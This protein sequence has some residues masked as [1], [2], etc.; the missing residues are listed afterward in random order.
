MKNN[1]LHILVA[2]GAG[3][4]GS[5]TTASLINAGHLVTVLDNLSSGYIDAVHPEARFVNGDTSDREV[6][7][8]ICDDGIDVAMHFAA[9]IEVGESV[10]DP[11]K[12]YGNNLVKSIAFFDNLITCGVK[13]L[14]FS[15]TAAVYGEPD[16]IP[17]T[18]DAVLAPVNPYGWSKLMVETVLR[19]YEKAYNFRS[20]SLRY[21]NAGGAFES[22]GERHNPES[23]LIP[24][25]LDAVIA[26]V[27][28]RVYG[29]DY[30]TRD[31]SCIRDYIYVGDLAQ[32]H[33]LAADYLMNGGDTNFFNLGTGSGYTVLEVIETVRRVIGKQ[34]SFTVSDRREGDSPALVASPV[35]AQEILGW[36]QEPSGLEDIVRTAWEMKKNEV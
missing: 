30:N 9:F 22:Y 26:G 32:A 36:T 4:I 12:Y 25:I 15:S 28:L 1:N 13:R 31:G 5:V 16:R 23:H 34:V 27:P 35:K 33:I 29:N 19:D 2:G 21:F 18:E 6:I 24:R 20:V 8:K 7:G 14:V 3:Y 17:L 10:T 11:S